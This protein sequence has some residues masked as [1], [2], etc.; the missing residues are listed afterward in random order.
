MSA[1][2]S[3]ARPLGGVLGPVTSPFGAGGT[4]DR[5]ALARNVA[6]HLAAGLDGVVVAGSTGEA[7]LLDDAER[8]AAVEVAR[9][10]VPA[11]RRLLA[12][13]GAESTRETVRRAREAAEGGADAVLVVAPH[14]YA[15]SL[16]PEARA[17]Q[18]R[19]HFLAVADASPAP[20]VLYN[21]PKF[22]HFALDPAL[23]A[24]LATHG[25][26]VGIKDSSG[27][28]ALLGGYLA[29][30]PSHFAVLTGSGAGLAAALAAGARGGILAVALFA[31]ALARAVHDAHAAGDVGRAA[32]AQARLAQLARE[33]VGEMGVAGVKAALDAVGLEGGAPR[34]PLLPL[35][36]AERA[37]VAAL[38]SA[39]GVDA[40]PRAA[41]A[42]AA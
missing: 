26:V 39:Q 18:L 38:L 41:G 9:E 21:I 24:E 2:P 32:A 42:P 7:A 27:D 1:Q 22:M 8:R 37:R 34:L 15:G 14:Y 6:A 29:A 5:A 35:R 40:E 19:A 23:V 31:P 33:I 20:V 12:G 17:E 30:C 28:Q 13:V 11:E 25:N 3:A 36:P 10:V 16:A 4:L